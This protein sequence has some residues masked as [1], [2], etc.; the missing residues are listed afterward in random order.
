[1]LQDNMNDHFAARYSALRTRF[2]ARLHEGLTLIDA[3]LSDPAGGD[4][5]GNWKTLHIFAH[6][7]AGTAGSFGFAAL[8]QVALQFEFALTDAACLSA[9]R[10]DLTQATHALRHALCTALVSAQMGDPI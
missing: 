9:V 6:Q 1:M 2:V 4:W 10:H 3:R 7:L 8:G 5:Q